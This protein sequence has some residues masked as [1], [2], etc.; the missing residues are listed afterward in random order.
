M[1][2]ML[3]RED[4]VVLRCGDGEV[5]IGT[6]PRWAIRLTGLSPAQEAWV[7]GLRPGTPPPDPDEESADLVATLSDALVLVPR[8]RRRGIPVRAPSD[9]IGDRRV[10]SALRPDAA[11][12][13]TLEE[14]ARR[15]VA[16]SGLGRLGSGLAL[17]LAT[18]GVGELV[19]DDTRAIDPADVGPAGFSIAHV[20]RPRDSTV[21][22]TIAETA[23]HVVTD[24]ASTPDVIVLVEE[25]AARPD[26][27]LA[28]MSEGDRKS[29]V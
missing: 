1:T 14:R 23:P 2:R 27:T 10:L 9:G 4:T 21:R 29:V 17:T 19:L 25:G 22:R 8:H 15:T 13:R 3:V 6:D 20:G 12:R 7:H 28:L 5:Q 26:R 24:C 16:I 18:A 11:G